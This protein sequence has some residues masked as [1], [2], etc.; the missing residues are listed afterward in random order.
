MIRGINHPGLVVK[1]MDQAM[2][3]YHGV[4]GLK[5]SSEPTDFAEGPDVDQAIRVPGAKVKAATLFVSEEPVQLLELL[6]F[7]APDSEIDSPVPAN[8]LGASHICFDVADVEAAKAELES[9]G[10]EFNGPINV[11]DEGPL[12]GWRWVYFRDPDG[13]NLELCEVAYYKTDERNAAIESYLKT[14]H[15]AGIIPQPSVTT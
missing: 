13:Y 9:R 3:F 11:V 6:E 12:S 8:Y 2:G 15:A 1:N 14:L 4:L 7:G 10:V 5:I